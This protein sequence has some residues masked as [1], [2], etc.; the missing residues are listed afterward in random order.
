VGT[1]ST[2]LLARWVLRDA[3]QRALTTRFAGLRALDERLDRHGFLTMLILRFVL[4]LAPP[5]NW[6]IGATGVRVHHYVAGTALGVIPGIA[7]TVFFAEAIATRDPGEA[8][9]GGKT[10]VGALLIAVFL[11]A[12]VIGG[13]RVF[14]KPAGTPGV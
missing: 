6:A 12:L 2:F 8:L 3:F 7:A 9:L 4:F 5:L 14:G 10:I 11:A 1:T 13:R